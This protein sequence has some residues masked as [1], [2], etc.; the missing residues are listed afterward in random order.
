MS[1]KKKPE[2]TIN[3]LVQAISDTLLQQQPRLDDAFISPGSRKRR[4]LALR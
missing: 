4:R 2:P 1:R 3:A